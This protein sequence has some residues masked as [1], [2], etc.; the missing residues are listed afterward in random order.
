MTARLRSARQRSLAAPSRQR[1]DLLRSRRQLRQIVTISR[2]AH[3]RH[4]IPHGCPAAAE[5]PGCRGGTDP[6]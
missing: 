2:A 5:Q 1:A 4:P 3:L 6:V